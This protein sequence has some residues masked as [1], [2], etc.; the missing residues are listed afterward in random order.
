VIAL[1]DLN[2]LVSLAW[3]NHVHHGVSRQWFIQNHANG[4]ATCPVTESGF[5][6]VSTNRRVIPEARS[7][8]EAASVLGAFLRMPGHE[9]WGDDT[10]LVTGADIDLRTVRGYRQI[11]DAHLLALVK[12]A[13]GALVTCDRGASQLAEQ[14]DVAVVLL[15]I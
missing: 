15:G 1:L 5:L 13:G 7:A 4:W 11:T 2:V 10:S 3:P 14:N 6:R 9:F 12:R 8:V